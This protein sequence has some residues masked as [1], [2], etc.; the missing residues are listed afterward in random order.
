MAYPFY[1]LHGFPSVH[2]STFWLMVVFELIFLIDIFV[3]FFL[4]N[5]NE[6]GESLN[7]SIEEI[8]LAYLQGRFWV[9]CI[10]L[11]PFGMLSYFDSRLK[12]FWLIKS[13]RIK[14]FNYYLSDKFCRPFICFLISIKQR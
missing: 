9:D 3:R 8:S 7:N 12:V 14:E 6:V 4:Q 10:T 1:T 13:I 5:I 2:D 11:V